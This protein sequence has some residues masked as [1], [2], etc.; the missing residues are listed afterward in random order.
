MFGDQLFSSVGSLLPVL[1]RVVVLFDAA[2]LEARRFIWLLVAGTW[3]ASG[4]CLPGELI[5]SKGI[6]LGEN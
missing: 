3:I 5:G 2:S 4:S 1:I 6:R